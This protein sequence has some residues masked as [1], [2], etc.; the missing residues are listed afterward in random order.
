MI[1]MNRIK[2]LLLLS[3]LLVLLA[4][5][6]ETKTDNS[7]P[8]S[9]PEAEGVSS[10]AILEF[11]GAADKEA[12]EIHSFML[13]RHGKVIAEG[14]WKPY[15]PEHKHTMYSLSKSFTSTAVGF[16]VTEKLLTVNDKVISFFPD[17]VP[18]TI[19]T[20]LAQMTVK[21]LLT[22]SVGMD[23]DPTFRVAGTNGNW[24][25]TFFRTPV[26]N[27]PGSKFLYNSMATYMLSAIVQ[28]VTGKKVID[29]LTPRF[30]EPLGI[31]GADWEV[32]SQ[33]VNTG[34]WGLRLKTEDI[35]KAGQFYLQKG[36]WNGKQL[37]PAEW[38]EEATSSMID[39][40]PDADQDKKDS[41]DWMQGYGYQFWR[42]RNNAYRGDGAF[43]QYM[44]VMPDQ[45]A[46]IAITSQTVD[47]QKELN[48]VWEYL[49]PGFAGKKLHSDEEAFSKLNNR[50]ASL[51]LPVYYKSS[52]SPLEK[53]LS[54][55][56]YLFGSNERQLQSLKL[57]ISD[58][59]ATLQLRLS[60]TDYLLNFTTGEWYFDVTELPGPNLVPNKKIDIL[61]P[62]K[63]AG[64]YTWLDDNS[65]EFTL[66]YIESPHTETITCVFL[67][68]KVGVSFKNIFTGKDEIK[69]IEGIL[70]GN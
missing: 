33:G 13:L 38:I 40:S 39:Q 2:N 60:S 35:A 10:A 26:L 44:I 9:T 66:R 63:V 67:E 18:D 8:R 21:D 45:D 17:K 32:N 25:E 36:K 1:N 3:L 58:T 50:L 30:F 51:Q 28:K 68:E 43:G 19:S 70:S 69:L 11:I 23:P 64:S 61:R 53:E 49:L 14:W 42:C 41:S 56:T 5:C 22:M 57:E 46:V 24:E 15:G 7:L 16:A 62:F 29:Y 37:L 6:T 12:N 34:G 4:T 52:S 55:K 20:N 47:M 59:L 54:G 65:A 48:L 27:E 31:T